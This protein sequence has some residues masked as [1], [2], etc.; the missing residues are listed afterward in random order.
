MEAGTAKS[1]FRTDLKYVKYD[2]KNIQDYYA[3]YLDDDKVR[4]FID[5]LVDSATGVGHYNTVEEVT[6]IR[7]T[8]KT[9]DMCDAFGKQFIF[10]DFLPNILR[11]VCIAGFCPVESIM[12]K[13]NDVTDFAKM[14]F[15]LIRPDTILEKDGLLVDPKTH[16]IV[17][18]VQNIKN[19]VTG[20]LNEIVA[21][22][23]VEIVNFN[24]GQLGNDVRGISHIRGV[25]NLLNT[26][27]EAT[28]AV[29]AILKRYISPIGVWRS[30]KS[31]ELL[32]KQVEGR[33]AGEDV[34][35]GNLSESE[36]KDEIIKF[37]QIDPRVPFWDYIQYLDRRFYS[38]SRANDIWYSKDANVA[39]SE[40]I[41]DIVQR[42]VTRLQRSLKRAVENFWYQPL[43]D[44]WYKDRECP[45]LNFGVE[46]TG[47]GDIE[48][49]TFLTKGLELGYLDQQQFY[50]VCRKLGLSITET[51]K[52]E[53]T[54]AVDKG[55]DV[56]GE[57]Q[58]PADVS[59]Q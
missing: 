54:P 51:V 21:G 39:S 38:Y 37:V 31:T 20:K 57:T 52:D 49:G 18:I 8:S 22:S 59:V 24:Y 15:T 53:A 7:Q 16:K 45:R 28:T 10:D 30:R 35:L 34:F 33:E 36:M 9:K 40:T 46:P 44:M 50:E 13:G 55:S 1:P 6:P 47:V 29:N 14:S 19:P 12:L 42:H 32:R 26:L 58:S 3:A 27:N 41:D 5:D 25:M 11:N 43:V 2:T 4:A 23:G 48:P 17:K 56:N